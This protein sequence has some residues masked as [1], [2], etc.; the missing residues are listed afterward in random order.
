MKKKFKQNRGITLI[1]LIITIIVMLILV[2]VSVNILIKSNLI[3]TAEK[4]ADKYKTA[5]EEE[6]NGAIEIDGKK[7]SSLD[8][9]IKSMNSKIKLSYITKYDYITVTATY[10]GDILELEDFV[11]EKTEGQD[12][13]QIVLDDVNYQN[14]QNGAPKFEK[15]DDFYKVIGVEDWN[16]FVNQFYN[17]DELEALKEA[18]ARQYDEYI[19]SMHLSITLPDGTIKVSQNDPTEPFSATY[20][21]DKDGE[22]EFTARVSNDEK[23]VKVPIKIETGGIYKHPEQDSSNNDIGIGTDGKPVNLNLW[24]YE[25]INGNEIHLGKQNGQSINPGY[26]NEN[27]VNG[28]IMGTVP[29]YIYING[30]G[31]PYA[32]TSM[33]SAFLNCSSL[34]EAPEL[35][36]TVTNMI[37]TFSNCTSLIK[38]PVIPSSVTDLSTAFQNCTSLKIAPTIPSNVK[39][40]ESTFLRVHKFGKGSRCNT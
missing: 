22:Y 27:I 16:G 21:A 9:Y 7:Y 31:E 30:E 13:E 36:N 12:K 8:E 18:L 26:K 19:E 11:K 2:A 25:I 15:I 23:S 14:E 24:A 33:R 29:Q 37:N 28:K 10:E 34:V 17:G 35:P 39:D 20:F 5:T 1:A 40:L 32:V 6:K 38:A 4:A 3:G